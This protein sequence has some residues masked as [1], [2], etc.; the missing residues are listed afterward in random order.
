MKKILLLIL[1]VT[2]S[3]IHAQNLF[4]GSILDS[5][6]NPL[7]GASITDRNDASNTVNSQVNGD[8]EIL[9]IKSATVLINMK[10]FQTKELQL[11]KGTNVIQLQSKETKLDEIFVTSASREVQKRSEVPGAIS[12]I[13]NSK[14]ADTKAFGIDQ[15]VNQV[16]GVFMS[17]SLA[18]SNEQHFMAVR[19]PITTKALFL[20]LE[21][22][23][24]IRPTSVFNHNA[25]LEMNNTSFGRIEVLKGPA[26]SIYG[27]E[28]IGEGGN[29]SHFYQ[30]KRYKRS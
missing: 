5:Y 20:Y 27:S 30:I 29:L 3:H 7:I 10:G 19:S 11:T 23:L 26:S 6:D 21:D 17:T 9:L 2:G 28:A 16:P 22:G 12:M 18:A 24:P 25:L 15:L 14:I 8:F 1:L 13:S 4:K